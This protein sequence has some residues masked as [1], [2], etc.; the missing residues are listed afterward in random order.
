MDSGLMRG[1]RDRVEAGWQMVKNNVQKVS[2]LV[3]G[4]L[5]ASKERIPEYKDCDPGELLTEVC[6]LYEEKA[7]KQ[8]VRLCRDF[9][10]A[11][12]RCLLDPVGIHSALSNL[13]SNALEA[14]RPQENSGASYVTVAGRV[15]DARLL[16]KVSDNGEGIPDEIRDKLFNK[17]YS[18]KGAKGTGLGLVIT[19]KVVEEHRGTI[20]VESRPGLGTTFMIEIPLKSATINEA[21]E[22]AI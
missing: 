3:Q 12:G 11:M 7:Q 8:G 4:I 16:I 19:R 18:T 2:D 15:E 22:A 17:F 14:S 20:S 1:K 10:I 9:D 6:D 5:Y 13:V 21:V